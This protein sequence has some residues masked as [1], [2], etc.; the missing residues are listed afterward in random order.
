MGHRFY[1]FYTLRASVLSSAFKAKEIKSNPMKRVLLMSSLALAIVMAGC[2]VTSIYPYYTSKDV[3]FNPA[4]VGSWV[5]NPGETNNTEVW[6]FAK[7]GEDAYKFTLT[8]SSET[9]EFSA[10]LFKLKDSLFIDFMPMEKH[11]DFIPPHYLMS[12]AQIQPTFKASL[13]SYE[14]LGK[15]LEKDAHTI[16]YVMVPEESGNTNK[17][18]FVLSADTK[19]L[20]KFVLKHLKTEGAFEKEIELQKLEAKSKP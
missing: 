15:L 18:R 6:T 11:D 9:N 4:L 8:K 3:T 13:M 7:A 17:Q 16:R 5:E 14:W 12:V 10:H 20:Q 19:E 2:V 1:Q